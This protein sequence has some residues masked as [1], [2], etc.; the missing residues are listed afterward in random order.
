MS[1]SK[2]RDH[3]AV[4]TSVHDVEETALVRSDLLK[5]TLLNLFYLGLILVVYFTDAKSHYLTTLFS[6]VF[7]W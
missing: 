3:Q 6:R 2:N 5:I 1:K 4:S 7:K